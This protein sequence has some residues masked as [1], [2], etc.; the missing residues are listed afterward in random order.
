MLNNRIKTNQS[1]KSLHDDM[2]STTVYKTTV[3]NITVEKLL[4]QVYM[5]L[6]TTLLH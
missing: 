5:R 3:Y 4:W 6:Q 1:K 2:Y